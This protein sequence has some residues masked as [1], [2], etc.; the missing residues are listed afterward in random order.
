MR[1]FLTFVLLCISFL[2]KTQNLPQIT[3]PFDSII[4][5]YSYDGVVENANGD[6][7]HL[8]QNAR[9]YLKLKY[10]RA[11]YFEDVQNQVLLI[12]CSFPS[13]INSG[14]DKNVKVSRTINFI[15]RLD[16]QDYRFRYIINNIKISG[17]E[18]G[19]TY[20]VPL[21]TFVRPIVIDGATKSIR[22][23]VEQQSIINIE[24]TCSTLH[25][26]FIQFIDSLTENT[27]HSSNKKDW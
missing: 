14:G 22:K 5:Q 7:Q 12:T 26:N 10:P 16:F 3:I 18:A 27:L 6:A 9:D 13:D 24:L 17:N 15:L 1:V 8:Y 4:E 23:K 25:N 11:Q 2:S 19:T 20:E 21:E